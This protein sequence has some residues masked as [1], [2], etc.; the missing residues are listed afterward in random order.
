MVSD[1][2]GF[3]RHIV[4]DGALDTQVPRG[5]VR[6][7]EALGDAHDA[8][9]LRDLAGRRDGHGPVAASWSCRVN[10]NAW[11]LLWK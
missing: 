5:H 3:H 4:G 8:A 7:A 11:E 10:W 1:V 9:R 2:A 6:C